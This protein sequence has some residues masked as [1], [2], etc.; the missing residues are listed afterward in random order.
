[1]RSSFMRFLQRCYRQWRARHR[2]EPQPS[3]LVSQQAA[4]HATPAQHRSY[5][6]NKGFGS[7]AVVPTLKD[8]PCHASTVHPPSRQ[9]SKD[10][11]DSA[12]PPGPL[13]AA[14]MP[15]PQ[16]GAAAA[17]H[18]HGHGH[19]EAAACTG[20][21][22]GHLTSR[23]NSAHASGDLGQHGLLAT[24]SSYIPPAGAAAAAAGD[25]LPITSAGL[26][27]A[28]ASGRM[29]S[30]T[31][32]P[33]HR[34]PTSDNSTSFS[35][36]FVHKQSRGCTPGNGGDGGVDGSETTTADMSSWI[37]TEPAGGG[38]TASEVQ[39]STS[40]SQ[41]AS[42]SQALRSVMMDPQPSSGHGAH[43]GAMEPSVAE[44]TAVAPSAAM[45]HLTNTPPAAH[46][47][48]M[49]PNSPQRGAAGGTGVIGCGGSGAA[50]SMSG[51]VSGVLL[52]DTQPPSASA[53]MHAAQSNAS[54]D[55]Q[56]AAPSLPD[57]LLSPGIDHWESDERVGKQGT[58]APA[59]GTRSPA[60]DVID[61]P[62]PIYYPSATAGPSSA[63]SATG[64]PVTAPEGGKAKQ[65]A[66]AALSSSPSGSLLG[67]GFMD[68]A[69]RLTEKLKDKLGWKVR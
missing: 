25:S 33:G 22:S 15:A 10:C 60:R 50:D 29:A 1:M 34:T 56:L 65:Q 19:G 49:G 16:P 64:V 2:R 45:I 27:S 17:G 30:G 32:A 58:Q 28:S 37:V 23:T 42:A 54:V 44:A 7:S 26:G 53:S 61:E 12:L 47:L 8:S 9:V 41:Y 68:K 62:A 20:R 11:R 5:G 38:C 4:Q 52:G 21:S 31:S 46:H 51:V 18:G 43:G 48:P 69:R 14:A 40:S 67:G 63:S 24:L 66:P 55:V 35:L 59:T 6:T 57:L 39:L 36:H 3:Q 13:V